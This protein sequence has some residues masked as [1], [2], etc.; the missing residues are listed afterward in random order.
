MNDFAEMTEEQLK[1]LVTEGRA[2][3]VTGSAQI[4]E[5]GVHLTIDAGTLRGDLFID[6]DEFSPL[7][8][9]RVMGFI[10]MLPRM[11]KESLNEMSNAVEEARDAPADE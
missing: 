3:K 9:A 11:F 7:G 5:G 8:A 4:T 10:E 2:L 6:R 1:E